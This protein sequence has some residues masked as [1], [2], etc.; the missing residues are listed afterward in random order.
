[1][2]LQL[3]RQGRDIADHRCH[4]NEIVLRHRHQ[5]G[6]N[7]AI[8]RLNANL[9]ELVA[10]SL[11][12][13]ANLAANVGDVALLGGNRLF[14]TFTA[15]FPYPACRISQGLLRVG[16][17]PCPKVRRSCSP[18]WGNV[19][20]RYRTKL[21]KARNSNLKSKSVPPSRAVSS[22]TKTLRVR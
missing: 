2:P 17:T 9:L 5:Q 7:V 10:K 1:Q 14:Q 6:V 21:R 8:E 11:L 19:H 4:G 22:T 16:G 3:G 13:F 15:C 18:H 20:P 12:Q